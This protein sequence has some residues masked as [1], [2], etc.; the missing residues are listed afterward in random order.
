MVCWDK[1]VEEATGC[2]LAIEAGTDTLGDCCGAHN[3]YKYIYNNV[4]Y[5]LLIYIYY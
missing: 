4:M 3:G 2:M 5:I 1:G